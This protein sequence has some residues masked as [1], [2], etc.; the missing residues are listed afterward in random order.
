MPRRCGHALQDLALELDRQVVGA[1]VLVE[2]AP[3]IV[4]LE[5]IGGLARTDGL[6]S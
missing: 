4:G 2:L 5:G 1:F 6:M 3:R